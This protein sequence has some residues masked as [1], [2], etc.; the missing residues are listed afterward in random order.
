LALRR[1][2]LDLPL[3]RPL[4][5]VDP[6]RTPWTLITV[7]VSYLHLARPAAIAL[8]LVIATAKA[9]LVAAFFMHL[10]SEKRVIYGVLALT[11]AFFLLVLFLPSLTLFSNSGSLLG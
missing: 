10:I 1:P 8:A 11:F 6:R 5:P 2:G 4:P 3:P 7:G 9:G